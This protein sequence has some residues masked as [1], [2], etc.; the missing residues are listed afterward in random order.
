MKIDDAVE[1]GLTAANLAGRAR[2]GDRLEA[3]DHSG[4]T[5]GKMN[6][7]REPSGKL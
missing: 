5:I 6:Q 7:S 2:R 3:I 1:V 4:S